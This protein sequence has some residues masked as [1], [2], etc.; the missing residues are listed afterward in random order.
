MIYIRFYLN[1]ENEKYYTF[2]YYYYLK[3]IF[4]RLCFKVWQ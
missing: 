1:Q 3:F 4:S 2:F